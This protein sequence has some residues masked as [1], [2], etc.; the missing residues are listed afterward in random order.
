MLSSCDGTKKERKQDT[1]LR[2]LAD[3]S[4]WRKID[5]TYPDFAIDARNIRLAL[6]THGMNSFGEM[7]SSHNTWPVTLCIYNLPLWLWMKRKF[8]MMPV[9]MPDLK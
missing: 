4:Q 6:S 7:S 3:G 2:Y 5:R 9:L 8:I 1:I